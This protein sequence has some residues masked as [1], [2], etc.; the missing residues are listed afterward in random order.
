MKFQR[1]QQD[2]LQPPVVGPVPPSWK[3]HDH[4]RETMPKVPALCTHRPPLLEAVIFFHE[5]ES[6]QRRT[7]ELSPS[8]RRPLVALLAAVVTLQQ[9]SRTVL[10]HCELTARWTHRCQCH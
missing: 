7:K 5:R 6:D 3:E 1:L 9:K 2:S 8:Y 10:S 4:C